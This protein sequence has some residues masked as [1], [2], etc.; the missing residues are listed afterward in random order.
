M[1]PFK[2]S[3]LTEESFAH[4]P[5]AHRIFVRSQR[6]HRQRDAHDAF[7]GGAWQGAT[8]RGNSIAAVPIFL[9]VALAWGIILA[10]YEEGVVYARAIWDRIRKRRGNRYIRRA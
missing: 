10:V 1:W 4:D 2:R 3:R 9:L 8:V 5:L 7:W 6:E